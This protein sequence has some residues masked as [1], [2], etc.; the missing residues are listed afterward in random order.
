MADRVF[1]NPFEQD[2][3]EE[4]TG[5]TFVNPYAEVDPMDKVYNID[6]NE[7]TPRT[8]ND[9]MDE[10]YDITNKV[11]V[12]ELAQA[13]GTRYYEGMS[14]KDAMTEYKRI[15]ELPNSRVETFSGKVKYADEITGR[16]EI[17][18][19]PEPAMFSGLVESA[20]SVLPEGK[21]EKYVGNIARL[22]GLDIAEDP[23]IGAFTDPPAKVGTAQIFDAGVRESFDDMRE[24]GAAVAG[25]D[26]KV[27]ELQRTGASIDSEDSFIDGMIAD[28]G[29]AL[30]A[31]VLGDKGIGFTTKLVSKLTKYIPSILGNI[32]RNL[33]RVTGAEA[34]A[35]STVGTEDGNLV[36]GDNS[37]L[38]LFQG[39]ES[40]D[41]ASAQVV[42]QRVN[43]FVE[44]IGLTSL[45]AG[46]ARTAADASG[47]VVDMF[48]G[49][50]L[51]VLGPKSLKEAAIFN[52]ITA[53]LASV[54]EATTEAER[55]NI[56][57]S[58]TDTI[59]ANKEIMVASLD[60]SKENMPVKLDTL[61]A[62]IR[63][64]QDPDLKD[65]FQSTVDGLTV[66]PGL[67]S[68]ETPA[69]GLLA[70][71]S[72][73]A[74]TLPKFT[75]A[76]SGP[77]KR[78]DSEIQSYLDSIDAPD[79]DTQKGAMQGAVDD[80]SEQANEYVGRSQETAQQLEDRY[81]S[82]L[83]KIGTGISDD[84]EFSG[85]LKQL[86]TVTGTDISSAK[87]GKLEDIMQGVRDGYE[88]LSNQKNILYN[89]IIGGEID[90][91]ALF[92]KL[93]ELND[94]QISAAAAQAARSNPIKN[95]LDVINTKSVPDIDPETGK[96]IM[97]APTDEERLGL[98]RD[99]MAEQGADFGYIYNTIRPELSGLASSLYSSGNEGAGK[100][101]RGIVRYID[102]DMVTFVE[103]SDPALAE[104]ARTAKSF[105]KDTF[106]PIF[107][108]EGVMADYADLYNRTIGR[109]DGGDLMA[110]VD[111]TELDRS[112]Y[113]QGLESLTTNTMSSGMVAPAQQ[114]M[115]ALEVASDPNA[116]A[117]YMVLDVL[118]KYAGAIKLNGVAGTDLTSMSQNLQQYANQLNAMFPEKA[119]QITEFVNQIEQAA[120][121]KG[122]LENVIGKVESE[123]K[124]AK[125]EVS[126]TALKG[127]IQDN[128]TTE[129]VPTKNPQAAFSRLFS[130][131]N[132]IN[133]IEN[134]VLLMD[135]LPPERAAMVRNG[136]EVAYLRE[137]TKN[138]SDFR[139]E[140]GGAKPIKEVNLIKAQEGFSEL[141]DQ[142][143]MIFKD[144]PEVAE[145]L[146]VYSEIAG[147]I[148]A[149]KNSR[150]SLSLSPTAFLQDATTATNRMI[151]TLIGP[152]SRLGTRVRA[153]SSAVFQRLDPETKAM[154][155]YDEILSNPDKFIELS[156]KY[157]KAPNNVENKDMLVRM[158]MGAGMKSVAATDYEDRPDLVNSAIGLAD[159]Y[160]A[161]ALEALD[162]V[163][164]TID[165][166]TEE[167][168]K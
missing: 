58:I 29:P 73:K 161:P 150:S 50:I 3:P 156:R 42:E 111:G 59:D 24:F 74:M 8:F 67:G 143:R 115:K 46:G 109:T 4:D 167:A 52:E 5:R 2:E 99:F 36:L 100:I 30:A 81:T 146:E 140:I 12:D 53:K 101:V 13:M 110:R 114:M 55:F 17:V 89:D 113:D 40:G 11:P 151:F 66:A 56:V 15:K 1:V 82:T 153:L 68:V 38:P 25:N 162:A 22:A 124:K 70:G 34:A 164:G 159:T 72:A 130:S 135:G 168:F 154:Q 31:A 62:L 6:G 108:G 83:A 37:V 51:T 64:I 139:P 103:N 116:M 141:L 127:F 86:E 121:S 119:V 95:M 93:F 54:T 69:K 129:F 137:F 16:E 47:L 43:T 76:I 123:I 48:A 91:D 120:K 85:R 155:I 32:P 166:Q 41:T 105:Y 157:N 98:F 149:N 23:K 44:A 94:D 9:P 158:L 19:R 136:M 125:A 63:G 18:P 61:S 60:A 145:A 14:F 65:S 102:D 49:P 35:A 128:L 133:D 77:K 147:F 131:N 132:S 28:G 96:D 90:P 71:L 79:R 118:D 104:A 134:L 117:D 26:K 33:A 160:T 39:Y 27:K 20:I 10:Y 126:S 57:K 163:T 78:L 122:Q 97:R 112:G 75:E 138:T 106:A 45:F 165:Q 148:Q 92:T 144:K 87:R 152:L 80:F 142:G 88:D 84:L 107:A 21:P 7:V